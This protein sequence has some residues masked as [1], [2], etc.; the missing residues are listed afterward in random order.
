MTGV[1]IGGQLDAL[2]TQ[3][4]AAGVSASLSPSEVN[5]P[6][7]LVG[8]DS[9]GPAVLAGPPGVIASLD[10]VVPDVGFP[11]VYTHLSTLI[12]ELAKIGV[13]NVG[14]ITNAAGQVIGWRATL[15]LD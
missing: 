3:L 14:S 15:P 11:S 10:L 5:P 1:N 6:G 2:V 12:D 8:L 9:L 7:V 13:E 4:R